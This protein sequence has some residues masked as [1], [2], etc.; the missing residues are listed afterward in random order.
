MHLSSYTE[1]TAV[2]GQE[3]FENNSMKIVS[4]KVLILSKGAKIRLSLSPSGSILKYMPFVAVKQ[5]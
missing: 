3:S 2:H 1:R 5:D 4:P